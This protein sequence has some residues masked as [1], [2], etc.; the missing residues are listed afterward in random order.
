MSTEL[1]L[2]LSTQ[3]PCQAKQA[4]GEEQG[5][6]ISTEQGYSQM[7]LFFLK[8]AQRWNTDLGS[9]VALHFFLLKSCLSASVPKSTSV[10]SRHWGRCH[11]GPNCTHLRKTNPLSCQEQDA[12][13][14][15]L[16]HSTCNDLGEEAGWAHPQKPD[17]RIVSSEPV[18]NPLKSF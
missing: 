16:Q 10:W 13:G 4:K 9:R 3:K 2:V 11:P 7:Y 1:Y 6:W 17:K 15:S 8:N 5:P 18:T 12:W 14:T